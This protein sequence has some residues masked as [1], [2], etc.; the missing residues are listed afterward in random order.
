MNK[1]NSGLLF[2]K[3]NIATDTSDPILF[4]NGNNQIRVYVTYKLIANGTL[5]PPDIAKKAS[6]TL[7][8]YISENPITN[9]GWNVADS[10]NDFVTQ[11]TP[12]GGLESGDVQKVFYI[13]TQNISSMRIGFKID[14]NVPG[15][16]SG[17]MTS[18]LNSDAH[19]SIEPRLQ[20]SFIYTIK[21][22]NWDK[23]KATT[24]SGDASVVY[25]YYLSCNKDSYRFIKF[26][27][28]G[29]LSQSGYYGLCGWC[30]ADGYKNFY[31]AYIWPDTPHQRQQKTIINFPGDYSSVVTIYD[32]YSEQGNR[33]HLCCT[34]AYNHH[35]G[36]GKWNLGGPISYWWQYLE[37]TIKVYDQYGNSG[38]FWLDTKNI[39]PSYS[40][41]NNYVLDSRLHNL[42]NV[43]ANDNISIT[44]NASTPNPK[45]NIYDHKPPF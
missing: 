7:L 23:Y 31:G 44:Q 6:I 15:Y 19:K 12:P 22:I 26:D 20:A 36:S 43:D 16:P 8:N 40:E 2:P 45:L 34:W 41:S 5:I 13:S 42:Y 14:F 35:G 30:L 29:Y 3:F 37:T 11:G 32:Q 21:D 18:S 17:T 25:N 24:Y 39:N 33:E 4:N 10:P 27:V 9:E 28:N 1:D 38:Y